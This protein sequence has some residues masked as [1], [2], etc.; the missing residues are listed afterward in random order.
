LIDGDLLCDLLKK[1]KLGVTTQMIE[2]VS[3]VPEW[4]SNI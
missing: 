1:L 2:E 3:I 4:F